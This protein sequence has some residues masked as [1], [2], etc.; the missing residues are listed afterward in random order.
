[1]SKGWVILILNFNLSEKI[2][3]LFG[4]YAVCELTWNLNKNSV[5]Y[6]ILI[7]YKETNLKVFKK[8]IK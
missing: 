3:V 8:L 7:K 6:I 1:M 4:I 2:I 5:L